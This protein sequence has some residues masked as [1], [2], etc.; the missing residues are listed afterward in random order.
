MNMKQLSAA[1]FAS[2]AAVAMATETEH[3]AFSLFRAP[4]PVVVDGETGDWNLSGSMLI[5]SDVEEYRDEFASW[6]SAMFDDENLYLLSRWND[7]TPLNNPGLCGSD[8][9]F[10]GDCLQVRMILDS[11]GAAKKD[12][13]ATERCCHIDAWRGRDGRDMIGLVYGRNFDKGG[14][15]N[16]LTEGAKQAFKVRKDGKGYVQELSIPWRLLAPEG[17][18][19]KT[20]DTIIMTYEPNFGTAS[21]LRITTKDF[22]RPGVV[23]DRVFAFMASPLWGEVKLA[24]KPPAEPL[25]VRLSDTR[26]FKVSMEDGVPVVDWTGLFKDNK[27][28]GFVKIPV[29]MKE[30]GYVSLNIKNANG[31]VVRHLL[32][33]EF[34]PKGEHQIL[35]DGLTTPNDRKVGAPVAAGSYTWEAIVRK[36]LDMKLV[37]WAA[38]SGVAPYDC[39]GGNWGGDQGNPLAISAVGDRVYMGWTGSEAGQA[40]VC[41]DRDGK[42]IW[43]QKRGGFGGAS[44]IVADA[45]N[46]YAYDYGQENMIYRLDAAN[47]QYRNFD[48]S[49]TALVSVREALAGHITDAALARENESKHKLGLSGLALASGK[50]FLAY[51]TAN[52]PWNDVQPGGD[53]I[54]VLDQNTG[55]KVGE[56]A[57]KDPKDIRTGADGALYLLADG[58]KVFTVDAGSYAL[59]KL[60]DAGEGATCVAAGKDGTVYVGYAEPQNVVKAFD[61]SGKALRTIGKVGGRALVGPWES[62]GMRFVAGVSV[63]DQDRVWVAEYDDKPRRFSCW[64]AKTGSLVEEFFGP[65]H[66]G[67]GGGAI[68]PT[69]PLTVCGLNCEWKIDSATGRAKCVA[70]VTRSHWANARFGQSPD[71]RVYLV[72]GGGWGGPWKPNEIFERI[73]PGKWARRAKLTPEQ[74]G[75]EIVG[76]TVWSDRNGDEKEQDDE[77]R[78]FDMNLGGW[79][80]GWYMPCNQNLGFGGGEYYIAVTGWTACGAP[81]YDLSKA[82]KLPASAIE[83]GKSRGGMGAQHN[84][85]SEDGKYVIYNG[86]YGQH[87]SDMPC[88]EI[89]TGKRLFAYPNTYVGVHGG[90]SAPPARQGLIRAA[91]DFAGTIKMPGAAG[92]LFFVGTDKGEWH[93]LNDRGFYIGALFEGDPMKI[94]WPEAAVPGANLN[95]IPPGMG[96]EDFG[97]SVIRTTDGK[98]YVQAGK[99]AF[100]DIRLEGLETIRD[101]ASGKIDFSAE[102]VVRAGE[103]QAKY[104][105][106]VDSG[107]RAAFPMREVAFTGDAAK[108]F[109]GVEGVA[110]GPE[111]ARVRSWAALGADKIYLAWEVADKTPWKNGAKGSENM[112]AMGDTVDFQ[113]GTDESADPKRGDPGKGDFRLSIGSVG[114]AP[115]A[116]VYR[117]VSDE[118][119]PKTFFS[120]VWRDG[121]TFDSVK[122]VAAEVKVAERGGAYVVEAAVPLAE[123]GIAGKAQKLRGDFGATFGNDAADDTV[124]RVHWAN[125]AT[126]LVADEVAELMF[127]PALWGD[128]EF[129]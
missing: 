115:K 87:N 113:L 46:V 66:Y 117:K 40:L 99:T 84:I 101:L 103:F 43:R 32:N 129:K 3:T 123:L 27:P 5:C 80:D 120:G 39:P 50:L 100:I 114:G 44:F 65:T 76:C 128:I 111:G 45:S 14:V 35:W 127:K 95:R 85:V 96:A 6:Q 63:S 73:A 70:V 55:K 56:F 19:P 91:Y 11:T 126:G 1:L 57:A 54:V 21:K 30:D 98:V 52:K 72:V 8:A 24:D 15:K 2:A 108:D 36:A 75:W 82:V 116:V 83:D 58:G 28:E 13:Q 124:L 38:N 41:A 64:D 93:I 26:T 94:K 105:A 118:K 86:H 62:D 47:G 79:I 20:G 125:Q 122:E 89:A 16:A 81:E 119:H 69:D 106:A 49:D 92:N 102:D 59:A 77:V 25:R 42:V 33:A 67:A 71:G 23:P 29:T 104:L 97:G 4:S 90:H 112:Y 17:Y 78:K 107:K 7:S 31:E 22:F 61:R 37:G 34:L 51:G 109:E 9:G 110:F 48:G 88:Y 121:V 10:A 18:S 68:C 12:P 53:V 74:K 60:F